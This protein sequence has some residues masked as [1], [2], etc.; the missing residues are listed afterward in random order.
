VQRAD[1]TRA[2][3][4]VKPVAFDFFEVAVATCIDI[5]KLAEKIAKPTR[6][7]AENFFVGEGRAVYNLFADTQGPI[8]LDAHVADHAT[9][10]GPPGE[11]YGTVLKTRM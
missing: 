3:S 1:F 10:N 6:R 2:C 11:N 9:I 4:A 8:A 7:S 5:C